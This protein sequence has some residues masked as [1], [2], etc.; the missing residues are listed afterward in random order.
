MPT[1]F[2]PAPL[3]RT[4]LPNGAEIAYQQG[5]KGSLRLMYIHGLGSNLHAWQKN[6]PA[7]AQRAR[8]VAVDLPGYGYSGTG[9]YPYSMPFFAECLENLLHLLQWE[10]VV[11]VGHSMGGQIALNMALRGRA[12]LRGLVLL[13]PA[14]LERFGATEKQWL[15]KINHPLLFRHMNAE[16]IRQS[17]EANF[18]RFP[19]DAE[20]MV[21]RRIAMKEEPHFPAYC[22]MIARCVHT[23]LDQDL[24]PRLSEISLPTLVLF[25]AQDAL[26]PN[27]LLHP[28]LR[29][30]RLA[31]QGAG[32]I[33]G[34]RMQMLDGCGHFLQWECAG[35]VNQAVLRFL[36]QWS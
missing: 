5:G 16:Q 36:D 34:S 20:V 12:R 31:R 7:V 22:E 9:D 19:P 18:Y 33:P 26:I 35:R 1:L 27:R 23:M 25:G 24:Y 14:G 15:R 28:G 10:E 21:E 3:R 11:L 17:I 6:L 30:A 4:L 2:P 8:Y 32:R 29:P 13:A